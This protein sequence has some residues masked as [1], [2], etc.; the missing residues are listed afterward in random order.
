VAIEYRWADGQYDRLPALAANLVE[1]PVAVIVAVGGDPAARAAKSATATIP[2]V[3]TFSD[4]PV[5]SGLVAS[6]GRPGA[7][8][9]GTSNLSTEM[10]SKRFGLLHAV[11]PQAAMI[12][13]LLNPTFPST[14]NQLREM[15]AAAHTFGLQV[16]V[17]QASTDHD[18]DTSFASLVQHQADALLVGNDSFFNMRAINSPH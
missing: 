4:D 6:L 8:I 17:M 18:I 9:T 15:Q 7:N 5:V 3:A 1:R 2:I 11:V 10:E 12:G 13:V 14:A 16:I